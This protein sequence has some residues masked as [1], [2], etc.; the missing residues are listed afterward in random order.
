M[1]KDDSKDDSEEFPPELI[2]LLSNFLSTPS[3]NALGSTCRSVHEIL[4]PELE[5]RITPD[6]ALGLLHWAVRASK[7]HIVAKLLSPPHL[8]DPGKDSVYFSET[9]LLVAAK[10][11]NTEIARLL[12]DAGAN[13]AAMCG[14]DDDTALEAATGNGDLEMIK[15]LLDH[16]VPVDD[17]QA[18]QSACTKGN[19]DVVKVLLE[20][21]AG[22]NNTRFSG[23]LGPAL[24]LAV[25]YRRLDVVRYLLNHGADATAIVSLHSYTEGGP[26][27]PHSVP[28]CCTLL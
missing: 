19:L 8:V 27:P 5:S 17:C 11:R 9:D 3:L 23:K 22:A 13:A 6:L 7:P 18:I 26:P 21:G 10:A 12:L 28:T 15:L 2:L 24:G 1:S 20:W 4:Q 14:E 25:R 16:G